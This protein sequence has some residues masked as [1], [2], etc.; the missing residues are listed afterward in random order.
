MSVAVVSCGALALQVR[1]VCGR[2]GWPVDVFPVPALLHNRP[3]EIP[4]AVAREVRALRAAGYERVVVAYGDCGTYGGLDELG[5][6]RLEG[7]HCYDVFA[8]DE[9]RAALEEEP[10]TYFLTDFLARTFE[11]TVVRE[12]GLDRH[13]ELRDDYFGHYRRVVWLAQRAVPET[14]RAAE[15][16][17][18]RIGLPLETVEVGT[19]GLERQLERLLDAAAVS[20]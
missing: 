17:A 6:E 8:R 11:H 20:T 3:E 7:D 2:R 13:P 12:L 4:G 14:R 18:A 1:A 15:W 9:V 5:V 10:G 19:R 16:A